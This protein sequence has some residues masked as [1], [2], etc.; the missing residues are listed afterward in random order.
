MLAGGESQIVILV[1]LAVLMAV[2]LLIGLLAARLY[3]RM[4][5]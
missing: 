4:T 1:D 3:P 2:T 5:Q